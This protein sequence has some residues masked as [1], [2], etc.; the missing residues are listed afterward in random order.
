[1]RKENCEE[2]QLQLNEIGFEGRWTMPLQFHSMSDPVS[3]NVPFKTKVK[4][5]RI[6]YLMHFK[7]DAKLKGDYAFAFFDAM[8]RKDKDVPHLTINRIDTDDLNKRMN[9][10]NWQSDYFNQMH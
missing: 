9:G 7:Q 4:N 3:F 1:M 10:I 8:L 2:L 6:E 5:D